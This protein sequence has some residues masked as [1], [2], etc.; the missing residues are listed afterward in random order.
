MS[1]QDT[2]IHAPLLTYIHTYN[3]A[4]I[5]RQFIKTTAGCWEAHLQEA[6]DMFP[7]LVAA[8]HYKY[9]ACLPHYLEAMES[10]SVIALEVDTAFKSGKFTVHQTSKKFNGVW[11]DMALEQTYNCDSK[12]CLF[13]GISQQQAAMVEYLT[14]AP[15]LTAISGEVKRMVLLNKGNNKHHED[16]PKVAIEH[17]NA[18]TEMMNVIITKMVNP[19]IYTGQDLINISTGHKAA[20]LDL[21]NAREICISAL[22]KAQE[23]SSM[24]V[25]TVKPHLRLKREEEN[26]C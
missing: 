26:C 19:S 25:D 4:F 16:T 6:R 13:H 15:R 9:V 21:I 1:G 5:T 24:K 11:S 14:V 12:T 22:K 3:K 23:T 8:G 2:Y 10:L 7:Y 17:I 20:S 18:T